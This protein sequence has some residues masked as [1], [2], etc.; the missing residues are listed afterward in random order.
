MEESEVPLEKVHEDIHEHV[1]GSGERW[2]L[3][4]A[5]TAAVLAGLAAIASLLSGHHANEGTLEQLRASDQ[6]NYYQAKGIKAAVLSAK[7][8]LLGS[9]GKIP[10]AKDRIK[11]VEYKNDQEEILREAKE[12]EK[13]SQSHM[14]VHVIFARGVTLF[15]V[16]IAVSAVSVLTRRRGFWYVGLAFG[17]VGVGFLIQGLIAQ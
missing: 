11:A 1:Q 9:L 10:D 17:V 15:Q 14:R 16:A 8:E 4:V 12:K 6:W 7:M 5:L 3:G 2:T 13:A